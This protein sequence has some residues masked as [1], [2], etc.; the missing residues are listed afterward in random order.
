LP[1]DPR[2]CPPLDPAFAPALDAALSAAHIELTSAVR[3]G[4][5]AHV[6]LLLVW[7]QAINLTAIRTPAGVALEHVADSLAA[8]P[9][10]RR[11]ELPERPALLDLGSGGGFPGLPLGLALPAGR[12][13]LLDSI[14]KK[15]RFL[16][17][18]AGAAAEA[19]R[20]S[21][22]DPPHI[23]VIPERAEALGAGAG[24]APG[25]WDVV[26]V[27][28]VGDLATLVRLGLPLLG[29]GGWLVAWKRDAGDGALARELSDA[30]ATL[31]EL[32]GVL[33]V[34]EAVSMPG[35]EDHRLIAV[36]RV[37][38]PVPSR[39]SPRTARTRGSA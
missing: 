35:L 7:T 20:A 37:P 4:I 25:G 39:A 17:V 21:G 14:A 32:G 8:L 5:E 10:L 3:A 24:G 29:Y 12:L 26:T 11:L 19:V 16:R 23:E 30:A 22:V 1:A 15:A 36:R 9:L 34:Q 33:E 31:D 13:G 18:A 28:A 38:S 6:R 2:A 27:R